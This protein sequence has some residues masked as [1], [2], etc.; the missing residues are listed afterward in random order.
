M[1]DDL[2]PFFNNKCCFD[3]NI[4]KQCYD[5]RGGY[6]DEVLQF[7][8]NN[9]CP[10]LPNKVK[11]ICNDCK[12]KKLLNCKHGSKFW[13]KNQALLDDFHDA[14]SEHDLLPE[15]W[16]KSVLSLGLFPK[17]IPLAFY[18]QKF[19]KDLEF[20]KSPNV[21]CSMTLQPDLKSLFQE[22][23][24]RIEIE[25]PFNFTRILFQVL[26]IKLSVKSQH[27]N[28]IPSCSLTQAHLFE[29]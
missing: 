2:N 7:C 4:R 13:I 15:R 26:P 17:Q 8:P 19:F 29:K 21:F 6:K 3:F 27:F 24:L 20:M 1:I 10:K 11:F 9:C 12:E 25:H 16:K 23:I 5:V 28:F 14:V 18:K 22:Q